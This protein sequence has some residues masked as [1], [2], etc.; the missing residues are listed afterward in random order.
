MGAAQV[1]AKVSA[2]ADTPAPSNEA[3]ARPLT[4]LPE[5]KWIPVWEEAVKTAPDGRVTADHVRAVVERHI[6]LPPPSRSSSIK[7]PTPKAALS[8]ISD[9]LY[10]ADPKKIAKT[11]D[12]STCYSV[13]KK[14]R[15]WSIELEDSLPDRS[16]TYWDPPD[17][18]SDEAVE[19]AATA[20]F[21]KGFAAL[22]AHITTEI[23]DSD[24]NV[25]ADIVEKRD[26]PKTIE[27]IDEWLWFFGVMKE[28]LGRRTP[29]KARATSAAG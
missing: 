1:A 17:T 21:K 18:A 15:Q 24:P 7:L 8:T 10:Y 14:V 22:A 26:V 5:D 28:G 20:R 25:L 4:K 9:R 12:P 16:G 2:I 27:H 23:R 3:Q 6:E 13:V 29:K 19:W 11:V